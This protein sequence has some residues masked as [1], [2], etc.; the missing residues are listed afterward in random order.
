MKDMFG[1][2]FS[3]TFYQTNTK[4]SRNN[5]FVFFYVIDYRS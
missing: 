1:L 2:G 5:Y 3:G 4:Q